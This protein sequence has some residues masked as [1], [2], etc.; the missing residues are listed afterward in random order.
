MTETSTPQA[1]STADVL[2]ELCIGETP[3]A[4]VIPLADLPP[5]TVVSFTITIGPPATPA[6]AE[7]AQAPQ[8]PRYL[9]SRR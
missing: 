1:T 4:L 3:A 2:A 5:G 8:Q 6:P 7:S 9:G